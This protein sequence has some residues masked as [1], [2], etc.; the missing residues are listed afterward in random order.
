M[1]E[2]ELV[3]VIT[4]IL[5]DVIAVRTLVVVGAVGAIVGKVDVVVDAVVDAR[6]VLGLVLAVFSRLA[7]ESKG[8]SAACAEVVTD[9]SCDSRVYSTG[10]VR[11][12][13]RVTA[14]HKAGSL[15]AASSSSLVPVVSDR[16]YSASASITMAVL[17][18]VKPGGKALEYTSSA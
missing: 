1:E 5:V 3:I 6:F 15:M 8:T 16:S 7:V 10:G 9:L 13:L 4:G 17:P 11:D 14:R 12:A 2:R 18:A